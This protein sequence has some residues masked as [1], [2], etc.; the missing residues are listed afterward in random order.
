MSLDQLPDPTFVNHVLNNNLTEQFALLSGAPGVCLEPKSWDA[1]KELIA[2]NTEESLA[3]LGR[4]P[5]G[6][7]TYRR[8]RKQILAEYASMGDFVSAQILGYPVHLDE[9]GRKFCARIEAA[10]ASEPVWRENDF[11]YNFSEGI[12]HHNLWSAEPLTGDLLAKEIGSHR[13]GWEF[14]YFV[15]PPALASIPAVWH[16]HIVSRRQNHAR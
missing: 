16:A 3:Q 5:S 9:G 10:K 14:M 6:I 12:E 8:Y 13:Q 15:N 2:Q 7:V 4:H 1:A 11:P